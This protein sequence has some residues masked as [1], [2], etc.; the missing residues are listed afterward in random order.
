MSFGGKKRE[1]C[2]YWRTTNEKFNNSI[3]NKWFND[4]PFMKE[5]YCDCSTKYLHASCC[6]NRKGNYKELSHTMRT[7]RLTYSKTKRL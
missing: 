1:I 3:H 4:Q 7:C 2:N 6:L 5:N